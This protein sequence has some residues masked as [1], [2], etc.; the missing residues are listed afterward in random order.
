MSPHTAHLLME[1]FEVK[2]ISSSPTSWL[3]CRYVDATFFIQ[4]AEHSPQFLQHIN[5]LDPYIHLTLENPKEDGSIPFLDTL[6]SPGSTNTLTTSVY[7]KPTH[8]DQYLHW[9]SNHNLPAKHSVYIFLAHR[10]RVDCRKQSAL[11]QEEDHI[12]QA[13]YLYAVI[14]HGL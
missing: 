5:S 12:R 10:A 6:V 13:Q 3:W 2:V 7:R 4:Q 9:D 1:E 8:T 11:Q 14:P